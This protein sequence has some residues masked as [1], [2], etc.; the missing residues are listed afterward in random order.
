MPMGN[1]GRRGMG[2]AVTIDRD[3]ITVSVQ[4][5]RNIYK[6]SEAVKTNSSAAIWLA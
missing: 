4:E 6:G 5:K 2:E 3:E 1:T